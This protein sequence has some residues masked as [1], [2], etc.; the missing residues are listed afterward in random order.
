MNSLWTN[1]YWSYGSDPRNG[2]PITLTIGPDTRTLVLDVD[3][4]PLG[5]V[6]CTF[7]NPEDFGPLAT[8]QWTAEEWSSDAPKTFPIPEHTGGTHVARCISGG[9]DQP[10]WIIEWWIYSQEEDTRTEVVLTDDEY[11]YS[12]RDTDQYDSPGPARPVTSGDIVRIS[13][14]PGTWP[15]DE[16][17]RVLLFS[18]AILQAPPISIPGAI[19]SADGSTVEFEMVAEPSPGY[20]RPDATFQVRASSSTEGP[21]VHTEAT[22]FKAPLVYVAEAPPTVAITLSARYALSF[23]RVTATAVVKTASTPTPD[24]TVSFAV[25]G[26]SVGTVPLG[27]DGTATFR[28]PKLAKDRYSVTATF[29]PATGSP[30]TVSP[31]A[32]LRVLY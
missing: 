9:A 7:A 20:F 13:G 10:N 17:V 19:V 5:P 2:D 11:L 4:E 22:S 12:T 16:N 21:P 25:N 29:T 32:W 27:S 30:P 1:H 31:G 18:G 24:G 14:A 15:Q 3:I 6:V 23:Q 28:L 8:A 26:K